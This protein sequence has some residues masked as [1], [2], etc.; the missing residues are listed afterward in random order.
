MAV[1]SGGVLYCPVVGKELRLWERLTLATFI[2]SGA[3]HT[4]KLSD[5]VSTSESMVSHVVCSVKLTSI[6]SNVL[7]YTVATS[8]AK[9]SHQKAV[10]TS[11]E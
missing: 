3:E 5:T 4:A 2:V 7:A 9:V 1:P 8:E 10:S 6:N 11:P